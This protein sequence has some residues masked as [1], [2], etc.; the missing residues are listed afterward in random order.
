MEGEA[1]V[2]MAEVLMERIPAESRELLGKD[3]LT[4]MV[5]SL[6]LVGSAAI[7]GA[8]GVPEYFLKELIFPYSAGTA[9]VRQRKRNGGWGPVDEA[10][11]RLP[12]TTSE[13][14]H[15]ERKSRTRLA[16]ADRPSKRD[17]PA[18][19]RF[20][21]SD[22]FGEWVLGLMLERAGAGEAAAAVAAT[23]QDDHVIFFE[24]PGI[25]PRVGFVWRVRCATA[26]DAGRLAASLEPLYAGKPAGARPAVAARGDVVEV[27]L[28]TAAVSAL[29]ASSGQPEARRRAGSR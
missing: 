15:F 12:E 19:G 4:E 1:T 10:Y 14:L 26:S 25:P 2:V 24:R 5:S 7:E 16:A 13:I 29:P 21:Y 8:E 6:S 20:L 27:A 17:V 9:W 18:G 3:L 23:W 22:T 28:G 11:R